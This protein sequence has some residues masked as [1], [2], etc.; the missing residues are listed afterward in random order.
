MKRILTIEAARRQYGG[1]HIISRFPPMVNGR[2]EWTQERTYCGILA[3]E[4]WS[5]TLD[6]PRVVRADAVYLIDTGQYCTNCRAEFRRRHPLVSDSTVEK[7]K[8][9]PVYPPPLH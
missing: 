5:E 1:F 2:Q 6:S 8:F 3:E 9:T 7:G 4:D